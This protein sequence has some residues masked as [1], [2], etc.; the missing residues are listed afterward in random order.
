VN[1]G[2][3]TRTREVLLAFLREGEE[4]IALFDFAPE[5]LGQVG[6]K[7]PLAQEDLSR[8]W[9]AAPRIVPPRLTAKTEA[10]ARRLADENRRRIDE[11]FDRLPKRAWRLFVGNDISLYLQA[12]TAERLLARLDLAPTVVLNGFYGRYFGESPLGRRE[13]EQMDLL[14]E[15]CHRV[16]YL[17]SR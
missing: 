16:Y 9:V 5:K 13:R 17:P 4:G 11:A 14:K 7:M 3:T 1:S 2:K 15:A 8:I 6:G 10:E 12:G